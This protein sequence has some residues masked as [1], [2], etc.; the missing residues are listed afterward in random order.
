[1]SFL[2]HKL[3]ENNTL[4][5][6]KPFVGNTDTVKPRIA[7]PNHALRHL[8]AKRKGGIAKN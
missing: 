8:E 5:N 7:C 2:N 1:M 3:D 6:N 4:W